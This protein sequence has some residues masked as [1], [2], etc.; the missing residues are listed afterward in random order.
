MLISFKTHKNK[1]S[2]T[3]VQ[4]YKSLFTSEEDRSSPHDLSI[5]SKIKATYNK[6]VYGLVAKN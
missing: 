6:A 4:L 1:D 3:V 5:Y 2:S